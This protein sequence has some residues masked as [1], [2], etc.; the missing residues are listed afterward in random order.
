MAGTHSWTVGSRALISA[1]LFAGWAAV[2]AA[3]PSQQ[4]QPAAAPEPTKALSIQE[5]ND[6]VQKR[7]SKQI[8]GHGEEPASKVF[9]NIRLDILKNDSAATFLEIMNFGYSRALGVKCNYCHD[10]TDFSKDDKR[11]KR[12]AREM[13]LMH[14]SV[15]QQLRKME[16]LE[17]RPQ[18]HNINCMVCH[19]GAA[20]PTE[21]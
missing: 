8:E 12:A 10:E 9:K 7:I 5:S 11:P 1:L 19:R 21:R 2:T 13:A 16:N 20:K 18:G 17:P 4:T 15:N 3:T 14:T 6:A